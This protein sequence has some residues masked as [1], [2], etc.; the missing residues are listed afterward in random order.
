MTFVRTGIKTMFPEM[1]ENLAD[2]FLVFRRFVRV[3]E[4]VVKVDGNIYV[5]KVTKNVV[6]ESLESGWGIGQS[7]R[8]DKPF[9]RTIA[10][11]EG[12]LP[13]VS[14]HNAD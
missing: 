7:E 13:L 2:M 6:H 3:D 12:H 9:K 1:T 4:D 5:Q 8:H 10:S 14:V 11:L